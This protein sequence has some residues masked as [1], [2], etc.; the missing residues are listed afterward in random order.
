MY[1]INMIQFGLVLWHI[2]P[3]GVMVKA[4]ACGIVVR[5]FVL[6]SRYYVHFQVNTLGKGMNPLIF[7]AMG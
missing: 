2:H 7:P 4:M 1:L 3:R 6:Q 5:E